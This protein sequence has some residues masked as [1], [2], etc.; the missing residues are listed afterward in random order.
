[1]VEKVAKIHIDLKVAPVGSEPVILYTTSDS[2]LKTGALRHCRRLFFGWEL[3][4]EAY[5]AV[6]AVAETG[7]GGVGGGQVERVGYGGAV[8]AAGVEHGGRYGAG[9][10][11]G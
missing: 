10:K 1:M 11:W 3:E 7:A 8:A 5:L 2:G 6:L 4:Q 9:G